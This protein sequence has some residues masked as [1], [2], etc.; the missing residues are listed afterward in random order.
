MRQN[1]ESARSRENQF[2]VI[3][4]TT[5]CAF[6]SATEHTVVGKRELGDAHFDYYEPLSALVSTTGSKE[7]RVP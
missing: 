4:P 3:A 2:I 7:M 1:G 5:H 6:D